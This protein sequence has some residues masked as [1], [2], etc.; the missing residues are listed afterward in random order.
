MRTIHINI[1]LVLFLLPI[2]LNAQ[3]DNIHQ[4]KPELLLELFSQE[5]IKQLMLTGDILVLLAEGYCEDGGCEFIQALDLPFDLRVYDFMETFMRN[6][7][8]FL[9]IDEIVINDISQEIYY[10][11]QYYSEVGSGV[12]R[13]FEE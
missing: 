3:S 10:T 9:R 7:K 6:I 8:T 4:V 13:I 5:D 11:Y 12:V 2:Q 1:M